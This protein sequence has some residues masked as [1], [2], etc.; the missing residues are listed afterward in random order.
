MMKLFIKPANELVLLDSPINVISFDDPLKYRCFIYQ[1]EEN[2]IISQNDSPIDLKKCHIIMN[3]FELSINEKKIM[4]QLYKNLINT[5]NLENK[6]KLTSIETSLYDW[7]E[8]VIDNQNYDLEFGEIDYFKLLDN[9]GVKFKEPE[10]NNYL[11]LLIAYL[12]IYSTLLGVNVF[13]IYNL[14][15][16]LTIEEKSILSKELELLE[17]TIIDFELINNKFEST[18]VIDSDWCII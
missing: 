4:T 15:N 1:L 16:F 13:I 11:E 5:L 6:D 12:K 9:L 14:C 10:N 18:R 8:N 17:V 3:I 7:I 2:V